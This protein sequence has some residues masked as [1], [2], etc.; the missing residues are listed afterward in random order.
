MRIVDFRYK[1]QQRWALLHSA[2]LAD[3]L[4]V[5]INK[6][7]GT[8]IEVAL[9]LP[10]QHRTALELRDAMGARRWASRFSFAFV[11][12]PWDKVASHY[13][14]RLKTNQTGLADRCLGFAEWVR[15]AYGDHDPTLYDQAKMFMPQTEWICDSEGRQIVTFVGRFESL[16]RDFAHVCAQIGRAHVQLPHVKSSRTRDDYRRAYDD[17]ARETVGRVFASDIARFGYTFD[18]ASVT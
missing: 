16:E 6:T 17:A 1:L 8:S 3:V 2:H 12:N 15:R 18:G 7:G 13:H 14:F 10:F 4:F 9:G 5:H 11:R